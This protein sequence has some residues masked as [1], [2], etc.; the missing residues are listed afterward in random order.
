MIEP[1]EGAGMRGG[2]SAGVAEALM[3][4][5]AAA[6]KTAV[7]ET[8]AVDDC[9]AMRDI[10]V[11]VILYSPAVVPIE[12]PIVPTPAEAAKEADP[13]AQ[14]KTDAGTIP[15]KSWIRIPAREDGQGI[16]VR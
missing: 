3:P 8:I 14:S 10:R 2:R 6:V 15:K 1:A 9:P 11:V 5:N 4:S 7:I 16:S 12:S 13:E